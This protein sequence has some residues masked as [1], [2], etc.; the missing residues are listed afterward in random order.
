VG[1]VTDIAVREALETM[2]EAVPL[3]PYAIATIVAVPTATGDATP[4]ALTVAMLEFKVLHAAEAV[5]SSVV[6]SL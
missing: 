2:R 5:T 4:P 3:L 1:D 6:P